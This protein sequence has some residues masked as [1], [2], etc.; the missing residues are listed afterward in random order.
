M[1]F[2]STVA[3]AIAASAAAA[4]VEMAQGFSAAQAV[5]NRQGRRVALAGT[6][7]AVGLTAAA[8]LVAGP[9][10]TFA[11]PHALMLGLGGPLLAYGLSRLREAAL[12]AAG[13]APAPD[14]RAGTAPDAFTA[15]LPHVLNVAFIVIATGLGRGHGLGL[16]ERVAAG[17]LAGTL[18]AALLCRLAPQPL[19]AAQANPLRIGIGVILSSLGLFWT[20][21]GLGINWPGADFVLYAFGAFFLTTTFFAV[22]FLPERARGRE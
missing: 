16:Y 2:W 4:L 22:T 8:V 9:L 3:P 15:V 6:A 10:L 5:A 1:A 20:G 12:Q 7:Q 18:L 11:G 14:H 21:Q 19:P 17:A 13:V